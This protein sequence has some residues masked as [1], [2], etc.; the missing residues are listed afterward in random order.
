MTELHMWREY[1][2]LLQ[3]F[4]F[5]FVERVGIETDLNQIR[6]DGSLKK[7]FRIVCEN[8]KEIIHPGSSYLVRAQPPAVSSTKIRAD[9]SAGHS[10]H[11]DEVS[12]AVLNYIRKY[13]VYE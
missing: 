2:K 6:L 7:Q 10:P 9:I 1:D 3:D 12:G 8:H 11:R 4:S 5:V 13:Q